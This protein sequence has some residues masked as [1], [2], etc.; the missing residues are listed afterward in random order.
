MLNIL[1][2]I[3]V[4]VRINCSTAVVV[5]GEQNH[6]NNSSLQEDLNTYMYMTNTGTR[7]KLEKNWNKSRLN[8]D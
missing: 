3:S 2:Q 5:S 6:L 7:L 1:D 8:I 4:S